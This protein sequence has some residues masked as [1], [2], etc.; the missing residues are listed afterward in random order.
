MASMF[1]MIIGLA[2]TPALVK[3]LKGMYKVNLYGYCFAFLFRILF[4]A[5]GYMGNVPLMLGASV[6]AGL[7]TSPVTGELNALIEMCIRDRVIGGNGN[8]QHHRP[9]GV[10]DSQ[11]PDGQVEGNDS[12]AEKHGKGKQKNQAASPREI[13][14][15]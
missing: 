4:I 7:G 3:K 11:I 12:S 2:F 5:A 13:L 14:S 1:P 10:I 9:N 6:L 8:G 15:G